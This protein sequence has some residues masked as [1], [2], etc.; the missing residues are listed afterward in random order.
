[1]SALPVGNEEQAMEEAALLALLHVTPNLPH[2]RKLPEPYKT[3]WL[4]A[5]QAQKEVTKTSD[6]SNGNP[7]QPV[8]K[9]GGAGDHFKDDRTGTPPGSSSSRSSLLNFRGDTRVSKSLD[10]FKSS[11][12][13]NLLYFIIRAS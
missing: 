8:S 4:A 5:V 6:T 12:P 1:M 13:T 9:S 11:F 10:G 2:E 3:T 7:N